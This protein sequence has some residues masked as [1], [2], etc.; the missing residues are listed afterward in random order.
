MAAHEFICGDTNTRS[1]RDVLI[2]YFAM[3]VFGYLSMSRYDTGFTPWHARHSCACRISE[4]LQ[5]IKS[6][7]PALA[8][9]QV[10][11]LL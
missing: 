4:S 2:D 11:Q 10:R 7:A 9:R 3:P 1:E 6:E 8:P 5:S